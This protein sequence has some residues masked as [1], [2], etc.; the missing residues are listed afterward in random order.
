M[1]ARITTALLGIPLLILI[2]AFGRP[3]HLFTLLVLLVTVIALGEYFCMA[4]AQARG[5]RYFGVFLGFFVSLAML[6]PGLAQP[7][8][9]LGP[10]AVAALCSYLFL[11][12]GLELRYRH[13]GWTLLGIIYLGYLFPHIVLVYRAPQGTQWVFFLLLVS[14]T[15]DTASYFTG[16]AIGKRKL[17]PDVSPNKTI[18]GAAG[19]AVASVLVGTLG[20]VFLLPTLAWLEAAL[21][22]MGVNILAQTG[23]LFESWI[24]RVFQ[25]KDSGKLLPG[26]GGMLDRIDSFIFPA[27]FM[28]HYVRLLHS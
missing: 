10:V 4:F 14:T 26:H 18:E 13:L 19:G 17:Y 25:V 3:W 20:A 7:D 11:G 16:M 23:D 2:I 9:L 12:G 27:V 15:G 28:A 8:L 1:R 21:V 22:A 6:I 24:K 5:Q